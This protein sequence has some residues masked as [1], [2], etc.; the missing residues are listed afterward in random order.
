MIE[1]LK[2]QDDR[3]HETVIIGPDEEGP[4]IFTP[5]AVL[6]VKEFK[7]QTQLDGDGLRV[8][9]KG[10]GCAGLQYALDFTDAR[11]GDVVMEFD[12]LNV[13]CDAISAMH[14]EGTI[15]DYVSGLSGSG[16]KFINEHATTT[17][18]CGKSF[19]T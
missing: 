19:A 18:G 13:Y 1:A 4:L 7:E 10:G 9:V 11:E 2:Q 6:A 8:S 16:F 12:E 3:K 14:L 17:C 5:A 15:V